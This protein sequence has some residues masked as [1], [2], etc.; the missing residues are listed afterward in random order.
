MVV[1]NIATH[2][3]VKRIFNFMNLKEGM[4]ENEFVEL[5]FRLDA[6][7][8]NRFVEFPEEVCWQCY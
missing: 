8:K 2:L 1:E 7:D 5:F 4:K 6:D 3:S